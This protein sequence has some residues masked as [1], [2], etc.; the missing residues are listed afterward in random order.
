MLVLSRKP[1]QVIRIGDNIS[2][3]I[4]KVDGLKVSI[5][6]EAPREIPVMREELIKDGVFTKPNNNK[7]D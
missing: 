3:T 4:V 6:I 5:G 1:N 2:I 7:K